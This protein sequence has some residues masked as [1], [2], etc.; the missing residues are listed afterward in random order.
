MLL[1]DENSSENLNCPPLSATQPTK[2]PWA[3]NKLRKKFAAQVGVGGGGYNFLVW[4]PTAK[5][6]SCSPIRFTHVRNKC[7]PSV[8]TNKYS[9]AQDCKLFSHSFRY[10]YSK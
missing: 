10:L 1:K 5:F 6:K 8:F 9:D 2:E 3:Q 7:L 4:F